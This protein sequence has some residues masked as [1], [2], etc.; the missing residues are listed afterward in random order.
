MGY[1]HNDDDGA[2][3]DHFKEK[4]SG[5]GKTLGR[6]GEAGREEAETKLDVERDSSELGELV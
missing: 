1:S 2:G 5:G 4:N 3:E 6:R